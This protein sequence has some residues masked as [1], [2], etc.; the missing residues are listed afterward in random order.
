MGNLNKVFLM[1]N[2]TRDPEIR[3]TQTGTAVTRIGLAVNRRIRD[4]ATNQWR[5]EAEFINVTM[6]G[7][8]GEVISEYFRKGDPIFIEGRLHY[9]SWETQAGERR[10][11]LDVVAEN[12]EF[13]SGRGGGAQGAP[14]GPPPSRA[15]R[16][17][18]RPAPA[19]A[20]QPAAPPSPASA[21]PQDSRQE[22]PLE[23]EAPPYDDSGFADDEVPF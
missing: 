9:R 23:E 11:M 20:S 2:L 1:G 15:P 10:S 6:F 13:L 19:F 22:P 12:F 4:A 7:R 17:E 21:P 18:P 5:D 8:R 16:A 3:Y 14:G